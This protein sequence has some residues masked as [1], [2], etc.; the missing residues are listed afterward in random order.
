MRLISKLSI[1][2]AERKGLDLRRV[3]LSDDFF[4]ELAIA[5]PL[6]GLKTPVLRPMAS[7]FCMTAFDQRLPNVAS[8]VDV[9][10]TR[11][12]RLTDFLAATTSGPRLVAYVRQQP[13]LA[14]SVRQEILL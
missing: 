9:L 13:R 3:L 14:V 2:M 10:L 4:S 6:C 7:L 5:F 1:D 12:L 11:F 8:R